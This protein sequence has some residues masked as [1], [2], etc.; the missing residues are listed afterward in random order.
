MDDDIDTLEVLLNQSLIK[1]KISALP[2][3]KAYKQG[4]RL[5]QDLLSIARFG[6]PAVVPI[7]TPFISNQ[8]D[9]NQGDD[10]GPAQQTMQLSER[11]GTYCFMAI[12]GTIC[13]I[14]EARY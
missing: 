8:D 12:S 3:D 7:E 2:R 11:Q 5:L 6:T 4:R 10:N 1:T 14:Q 13:W 9:R